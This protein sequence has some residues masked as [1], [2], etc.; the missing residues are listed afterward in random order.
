MSVT[1][2]APQETAN[3]PKPQDH[4]V[5]TQVRCFVYPV[6]GKSYRAECIDLDIAAEGATEKEAR[7]GLRDAMLGYLSV[8]CEDASLRDADEKIFRKLILRPSPLPNRIHYYVG[9]IR[10][11][12]F[13]Q[14]NSHIKDRFYT[15][16]TPCCN[17]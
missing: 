11:T 4:S 3:T 7:R 15:V 10:Q 6:A 2:I 17:H 1:Q 8:V 13:Q 14:H 5:S 9:K 16:P 12:A